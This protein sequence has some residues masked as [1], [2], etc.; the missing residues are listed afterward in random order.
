MKQGAVTAYAR[1]RLAEYNPKGDPRLK[2]ATTYQ[3][4]KA[5]EEIYNREFLENL[6]V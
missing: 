6:K 3:E 2:G 4:Y 1:S 5:A